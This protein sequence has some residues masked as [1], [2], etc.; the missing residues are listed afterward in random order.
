LSQ[1]RGKTAKKVPFE[2]AKACFHDER[3]VVGG[4]IANLHGACHE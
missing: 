3:E 4:G 1:K 2:C